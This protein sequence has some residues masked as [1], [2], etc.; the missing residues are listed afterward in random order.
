M[1]GKHDETRELLKAAA[2]ALTAEGEIT[3]EEAQTVVDL[4]LIPASKAIDDMIM[5]EE[6]ILFPMAMDLLTD[7]DW[8]EI[9]LQTLE[10]GYCLYDPEIEWKPEGI[11]EVEIEISAD[12]IQLPSGSFMLRELIAVLN[13]LPV[14]MTFVDK[15]DKVKFFSQGDHRIFHRSRAILNRDVRMCHPP[16]SMHVVDQILNDFKSGKEDKAS[17]WIQMGAKFILIEYYALKDD[18]DAYFGTLEVSQDLSYAR[19]LE[20]EQRL[21]SYDK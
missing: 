6:E 3:T 9:Q 21:L 17:F 16:S 13:K 5:K 11:E 10:I 18:K 1:W 14:D 20:G 4:I 15:N 7:S 2:E 12:S 19:S 8:Y